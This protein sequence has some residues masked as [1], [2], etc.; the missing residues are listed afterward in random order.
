[1]RSDVEP[2]RHRNI[3]FKLEKHIKGC[4][5]VFLASPSAAWLAA[6]TYIKCWILGK[7]SLQLLA[8]RVCLLWLVVKHSENGKNCLNSYK[9]WNS[10]DLDYRSSEH[11]TVSSHSCLTVA[12]WRSTKRWYPTPSLGKLAVSMV[13]VSMDSRASAATAVGLLGSAASM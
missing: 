7:K 10:L 6:Q 5:C 2:Q 3:L 11:V 1:M 9:I 8:H 12:S 13:T 4:G